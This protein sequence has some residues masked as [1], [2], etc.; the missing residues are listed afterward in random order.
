MKR[1]L[2]YLGGLSSGKIVLW[3]YLL[4]YLAMV[5]FYFDARP[6]LWIN[7]AGLSVVIGTGLILSV[8]PAAGMAAMEKW[9]VARL[10]M[11]PFCVSS[12]AALIKDQGF[13]VVLS[14][15]LAENLTALGACA[16][17]AGGVL[18]CKALCKKT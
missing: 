9:A 16:L 3:C 2:N 6:S 12:F 18:C 13:F 10:F 1:L 7:S 15:R 8:M 4:W 11:M 5:G 14:P 17:F